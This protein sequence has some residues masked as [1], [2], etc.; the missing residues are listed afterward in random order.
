MQNVK[1]P[2][3]TK[4][5]II[6]KISE[7]GE[8][9]ILK[10]NRLVRDE[11]RLQKYR[12]PRIWKLQRRNY[13]KMKAVML[14]HGLG[15]KETAIVLISGAALG[16]AADPLLPFVIA[17]KSEILAKVWMGAKIVSAVAPWTYLGARVAYKKIKRRMA[18]K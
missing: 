18:R 13:D 9:D 17:R 8:K 5:V 14:K 1:I 7:M 6:K 10:M 15:P 12:G 2:E 4:A 11:E 16:A 3:K